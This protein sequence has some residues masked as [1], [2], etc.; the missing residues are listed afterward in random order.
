LLEARAHLA[1]AEGDTTAAGGLLVEAAAL[2][3]EA[4]HPLDAA[5]CQ[6]A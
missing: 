2:F 4:G 5:R 1:D 3:Q 6:T